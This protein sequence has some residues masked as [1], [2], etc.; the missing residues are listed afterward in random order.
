[1]QDLELHRCVEIGRK[2]S[3]ICATLGVVAACLLLIPLGATGIALTSN[4]SF[5]LILLI[6]LG[7]LFLAASSLGKMGGRFLCKTRS[8]ILSVIIGVGVAL[9]SLAISVLSGS[10]SVVVGNMIIGSADSTDLVTYLVVPLL[11]MLIYG[12]VPSIAL[13]ILYCVLVRKQ[14][15]RIR[16]CPEMEEG[17][18]A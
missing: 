12:G 5:K 16:A 17:P 15:A 10:L 8:L 7:A 2:N 1:M 9:G 6:S 14:L 4:S 3:L 18:Q 11:V 13:G